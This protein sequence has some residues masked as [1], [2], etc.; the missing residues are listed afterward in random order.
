M[1]LDA[2]QMN[3]EKQ[4]ATIVLK[5]DVLKSLKFD[6]ENLK[7]ELSSIKNTESTI[8]GKL[9]ESN[10]KIKLLE[11]DVEELKMTNT[12]LQRI[13]S[14]L[15][16][17]TST[18]AKTIN[19]LEGKSKLV[20]VQKAEIADFR[21]DNEIHM[22]K[23]KDKN[24]ELKKLYEKVEMLERDSKGAKASAQTYQQ[25]SPL[26]KCSQNNSLNTNPRPN[27]DVEAKMEQTKT[28]DKPLQSIKVDKEDEIF[29]AFAS[30]DEEQALALKK[31]FAKRKTSDIKR[32]SERLQLSKKPRK[33]AAESQ[34]N[35]QDKLQL[36]NDN[37]K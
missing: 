31:R 13:N 11:N 34:Q 24:I 19:Y 23:L 18:D 9:E 26:L 6:N 30:S 20:D 22:A 7:I 15:R 21:N 14:S 10:T 8:R 2:A 5:N 27:D 35:W 3:I 4:N 16:S 29:D 33:A 36:P 17:Q 12:S 1:I 37:M 28:Q 32:Q 25:T